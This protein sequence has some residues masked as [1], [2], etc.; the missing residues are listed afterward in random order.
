MCAFLFCRNVRLSKQWGGER[1]Q[2]G[3]GLVS[4]CVKL[5]EW[6]LHWGKEVFEKVFSKGKTSPPRSTRHWKGQISCIAAGKERASRTCQTLFM[7]FSLPKR[8][9]YT[10]IYNYSKYPIFS[11][12]T[13]TSRVPPKQIFGLYLD[14]LTSGIRDDGEHNQSHA[15][16]ETMKKRAKCTVFINSCI[17][18]VYS[19]TCTHKHTWSQWLFNHFNLLLLLLAA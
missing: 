5:S 14:V 1:R 3:P 4:M 18:S 15:G 13:T 11:L 7:L 19:Q 16:R 12:T 17:Q 10:C 8:R 9:L 2:K 6:N